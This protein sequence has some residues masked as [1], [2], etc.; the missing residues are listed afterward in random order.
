MSTLTPA[1]PAPPDSSEIDAEFRSLVAA[2][3]R[4]GFLAGGLGAA[5]LLGLAA[6]SGTGDAAS[7]GSSAAPA[8]SA[9]STP[10]S[11]TSSSAASA[12]E[13]VVCIDYFTAV[14]LVELG[15]TPAGAID[16]S[17][18]DDSSMFPAY[19]PVLK[20]VPDIG[21]ITATN[22]EAV[23]KLHPDLVLGPTPGSRFDNSKGALQKLSAVAKV[24]SVD[25]GATGDWRGPMA[26]TAALVDREAVLQPLV[27]SY[28][29]AVAAAKSTYASVLSST[30]VSIVS[31]SQ[32]GNVGLDLPQAAEGVVLAD[33]GVRFGAASADNG[34]NSRELSIERLDDLADSD[35]IL[36]RAGASGTPVSGLETL[37][38]TASWHQLP[39]VKAGHAY[40]IGWCDLCTYRWAELAIAD[41]TTILDKYRKAAS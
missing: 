25:F 14:F 30:T 28:R 36:Y 11:T 34:T 13:H 8:S 2:L 37:T 16:F 3:T 15:L 35:I 23:T 19:V 17:W 40:P 41:F 27:Q 33:L 7:T 18:V 38:T 1:R 32:D 31:Y 39:A 26:Q 12:P 4:R 6:C 5:G 24:G 20:S 9:T 21:E 22:F 10:A 29:A